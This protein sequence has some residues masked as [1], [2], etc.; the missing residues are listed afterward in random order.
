SMALARLGAV[1]NPIIHIYREREVRYVLRDS[2]AS[3]FLVPGE[4]RGFDYTAMAKAI[5]AELDQPLQ[6]IETYDSLPDG[7]PSTLPP[8]PEPS[9]S[10]DDAPI[11]WLY[12]TSG[13][14]SNPKGVRHTDDTL[15]A[16]A[17]GLALALDMDPSDIGSMAFPFA[18]IA[19]PD[20]LGT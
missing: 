19:G 8:P 2:G 15:I 16:G 12:Y 17:A 10:P 5:A 13:T 3:L 6:V 20:Y 7:D 1:Q 18:H 4:W 9:A 11:R 14:T